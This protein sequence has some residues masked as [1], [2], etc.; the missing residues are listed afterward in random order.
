M[1]NLSSPKMPQRPLG[2]TSADAAGLPIWP[3]LITLYDV[4]TRGVIDHAL[5]FTAYGIRE[6]YAYPASHL[7]TVSNSNTAG[8]PWLGMRARLQASFSCTTKMKTAAAQVICKAMQKTGLI[9]ADVGSNLYV[10]G[11]A[12]PQWETILGAQVGGVWRGGGGGSGLGR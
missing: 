10:T 5:R 11:E 2:W 6:A 3:G 4:F 1:F 12:S 8:S 7:V 9:L